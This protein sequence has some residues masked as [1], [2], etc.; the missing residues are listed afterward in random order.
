MWRKRKWLIVAAV[1]LV[2]ILMAGIIGG[3]V[4]AQTTTPT[5]TPDNQ[6]KTLLARVADILGIDQQKLEDAYSQ[7]KKEMSDEA[8]TNRL[9]ALVKAGKLTQE[10]ADQYKQWWESRPDVPNITGGKGL[11]GGGLGCYPGRMMRVAPDLSNTQ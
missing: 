11:R 10:Q 9:D 3:V 4:Y 2:V 1:A 5:P 7:A 8:L 6:G